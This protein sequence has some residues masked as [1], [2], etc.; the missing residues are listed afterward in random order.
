MAVRGFFTVQGGLIG[1]WKPRR[2]FVRLFTGATLGQYHPE[3]PKKRKH[4]C[5]CF[6]DVQGPVMFFPRLKKGH[7]NKKKELLVTT[8]SGTNRIPSETHFASVFTPWMAVS[9][10]GHDSE[11]RLVPLVLPRSL[12]APF[13]RWQLCSEAKEAFTGLGAWGSSDGPST[14]CKEQLH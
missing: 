1:D 5:L 9:T 3:C 2:I 11:H 13:T 14:W 4:T 10:G 12:C 8:H 6:G 7:R